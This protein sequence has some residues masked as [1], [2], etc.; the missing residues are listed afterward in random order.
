MNDLV[1]FSVK[2]RIVLFCGA[3]FSAPLRLPVMNGFLRAVDADKRLHTDD[4][5]FVGQLLLEARSANSFLESSPTNLEDMLT[6]ALM[7]KRTGAVGALAGEGSYD[8]L[9]RIL[10]HIYT[11]LPDKQDVRSHLRAIRA[12]IPDESCCLEERLAIV[13]TNYDLCLECAVYGE[14][15]RQMDIGWDYTP[16]GGSEPDRMYMKGGVPLLKLHGSVNWY[17]TKQSGVLVDDIMCRDRRVENDFPLPHACDRRWDVQ[18]QSPIIVPPSFL[19]ADLA[20][21]LTEVWRAAS[22]HLARAN[23]I[24][25]IGYSFPPSD[26]EMLYFLASALRQNADLR[27]IWIVDPQANAIAARLK[28]PGSKLGAHFRELLEVKNSRWQ[29]LE[30]G[31]LFG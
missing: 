11:N 14:L 6:F 19:K 17:E 20:P 7:A 9:K 1:D 30:A 13:T 23:I 5:Q 4:K 28:A 22:G 10:R 16:F 21:Q 31:C 2:P 25:F 29:S 27:R 24:A 26:T 18:D 8:R 12:L 3:G 15:G